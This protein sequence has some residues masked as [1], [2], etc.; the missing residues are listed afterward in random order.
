V[1]HPRRKET[2][3]D[4][5]DEEEEIRTIPPAVV[6]PPPVAVRPQGRWLWGPLGRWRLRDST[7]Y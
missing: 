5:E 6:H 4:G 7:L 1:P 2:D 3:D